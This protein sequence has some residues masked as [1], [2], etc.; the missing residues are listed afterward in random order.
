VTDHDDLLRAIAQR[1]RDDT[2]RLVYADWLDEH[3]RGEQAAFIRTEIDV[4]RRPEWDPER[5]RYERRTNMTAGT[6]K[7]LPWAAEYAAELMT[8]G[9][10][11]GHPVIRRGFPWAL[12]V[13]T[14]ADLF[15]PGGTT[16][17]TR[18]FDRHPV[19]EVAFRSVFADLARLVSVP[20]FGRLV[21][22]GLTGENLGPVPAA[23]LGRAVLER[24]SLQARTFTREGFSALT[25]TALFARLTELRVNRLAPQAVEALFEGFDPSGPEQRLRSLHVSAS[26]F[27]DRG[28][29]LFAGRGL[30]VG[31][32]RLGAT[33][34]GLNADRARVLSESPAAAGLRVLR[35]DGNGIGN[36]GAAALAASPH[37]TELRVLGLDHCMVGDDGIRAI[38]DSPLAERLGLLDLTGS[39]ASAEMKQ[40]VK[41]AM[42]DRARI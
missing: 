4:Y 7:R 39:P 31:L 13:L 42:G 5:I 24:L 41:D 12:G 16:F 11:I 20:W 18:V 2:P 27:G 32:E 17:L 35:L 9:A 40:H 14:P 25:R 33:G 23:A 3:G 30:R 19:E 22:L 6:L 15:T 21:G 37:L 28:F 29:D 34:S 36:A 8:L 1:P 38:L 10:W 26:R